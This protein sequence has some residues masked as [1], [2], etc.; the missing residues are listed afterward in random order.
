MSCSYYIFTFSTTVKLLV[1]RHEA[2]FPGEGCREAEGALPKIHDWHSWSSCCYYWETFGKE[3]HRF[4]GWI[5]GECYIKS[6]SL[7]NFVTEILFLQ[8]TWADLAYYGYFSFLTEKFGEEFLKDA[9]LL[10]ALIARVDALPNIKQW[11][12]SRPKTDI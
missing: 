5:W 7:K 6:S 1:N 11:V 2:S 4:F 3:W 12:E 8:L 9:S 10:K